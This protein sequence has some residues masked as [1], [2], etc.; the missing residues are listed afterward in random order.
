MLCVQMV[1][2]NANYR[3]LAARNERHGPKTITGAPVLDGRDDTSDDEGCE[4]DPV[5]IALFAWQACRERRQG[6]TLAR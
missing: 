4:C 6:L 1:T 5:S 2:A 3:L